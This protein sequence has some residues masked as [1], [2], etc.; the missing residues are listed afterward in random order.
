[1]PRKMAAAADFTVK[2]EVLDDVVEA[3]RALRANPKIDRAR[4]FVLGHSLGGML[5]PRIGAADPAPW[6]D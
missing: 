2:Q 5:I 4:V 1:M 6:P 3:V